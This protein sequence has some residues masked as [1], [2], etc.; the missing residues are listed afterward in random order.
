MPSIPRPAPRRASRSRA[1]M[2]QGGACHSGMTAFA[3]CS[4]RALSGM[5]PGVT[6]RGTARCRRR[7]RC[8]ARLAAL[9]LGFAVGLAV[10]SRDSPV[11]RRCAS[12][13]VA[14]AGRAVVSGELKQWHKV[15]LTLDGP[16]A[17]ERDT[18]PN[19]FLDYRL[20][21]RFA[22]ESGRAR[23]RRARLLRRRRQRRRDLGRGGNEV[24]C[25]PLARQGR[26]LDL[27]RV[28]R[29]G[30][31]RRRRPGGGG[32][33]GA[34]RRRGS[35]GPSRSCPPTRRA[36]T[37]GPAGGCSTS[38]ATTCGSPARGDVLPQGRCRRAGDAPRLRR[39]RRYR[40][41]EAESPA[42]D[43][44]APRARLARRATRRGRAARGKGLVGALNYLASP[45]GERL[46][47]PDL[48]R[49]RR[50]RQRLAVRR[51]RR[52]A[53]LRL[54]EARPVAGRLRPRA[55]AAASSCT[56]RRRRPRTTTS[57]S[58]TSARR[59]RCPRR[60]TAAPWAS[61][62]GSTTASWWP[63][64]ATRSLSTGT[65][66]RRTRRRPTSSA[67]WRRRSASSTRTATS[68]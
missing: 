36:A 54:L 3:R 39:L 41:D 56:S 1:P 26:P 51:A 61:S 37:S 42:Q 12:P 60:S 52:E 11:R 32:R 23:L 44:G 8:A 33:D 64:S 13:V 63:A 7:L 58:A 16:F 49:R 19:P 22:H 34:R 35:R 2:V 46:L 66:A 62:G 65:S 10:A 48:Q 28:V 53:P 31:A 15:T 67:R 59:E 45:G 38:A 5:I 6:R 25:A 18:R 50:R 20:T 55:V 9:P 68:S 4:R 27:A 14:A 24:A 57:G 17:R 21:V 29:E 47:L 43:L 30:P 40:G